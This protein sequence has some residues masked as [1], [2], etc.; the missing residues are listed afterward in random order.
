MAFTVPAA[1]WL[2]GQ[3]PEKSDHHGASHEAEAEPKEED[4][5]SQEEEAPAE[6]S[7]EEKSED[8]SED[9]S[10]EKSEG[11]PEDKSKEK[12]E[13]DSEE[14]TEDKSKNKS[15]D[16][17]DA[18]SEDDSGKEEKKESEGEGDD[19]KSESS[20]DG[21]SKETPDT[22]GDED[23]YEKPGP[24]AP[25]QINY[26]SSM[27]RG[28]GENQ[29]GGA[30]DKSETSG[31]KNVSPTI[32]DHPSVADQY[33]QSASDKSGAKHPYLDDDEKSKKGEGLKETQRI[34]GTVSSDRPL[35]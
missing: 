23:E 22:S 30:R 2:L 27:K 33:S 4:S 14:K 34:H 16:K 26:K 15:E 21:D 9:K 11:E 10:E 8:S 20:E 28:P 3:G 18:K 6:D 25:G 35:R 29:K 12:A 13:G 5:D 1:V 31:Q 24:N 32:S 7:S 17:S 19:Q